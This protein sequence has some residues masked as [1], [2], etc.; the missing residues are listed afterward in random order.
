MK[1]KFRVPQ[2]QYIAFEVL[3]VDI[4]KYLSDTAY[5]AEQVDVIYLA[6]FPTQAFYRLA[7]RNSKRQTLN[8]VF[9]QKFGWQPE[10]VRLAGT[11][12]QEP[13]LI[14]GSF[15]DGWSRLKQFEEDIVKKSNNLDDTNI[16]YVLNYYDFY[17]QKYGSINIE[18]FSISA[19]ADEHSTLIRYN[20]N[21]TIIGELVE[22]NNKD[23]LLEG[24]KNIFGEDGIIGDLTDTLN[25]AS[26]I[27]S[28]VTQALGGLEVLSSSFSTLLSASMSS[29]SNYTAAS[30]KVYS[31]I[32]TIF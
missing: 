27:I 13:R 23:F 30:K 12:G 1:N 28:P 8:K 24:L 32:T 3:K 31:N 17:H 2:I 15:M 21:F 9:V 20:C 22:T 25:S 14:A 19:N 7:S 11:F 10:Q 6:V 4:T 29:L 5:R 16:I 18:D 26:D